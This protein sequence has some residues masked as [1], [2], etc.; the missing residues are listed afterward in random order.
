MFVQSWDS[1]VDK[2]IP[3]YLKL[4]IEDTASADSPISEDIPG[5]IEFRKCFES[6]L[7]WRLEVETAA[8]FGTSEDDTLQL[9]PRRQD[10]SA[11]AGEASIEFEQAND[12]AQAMTG[13]IREFQQTRY[14]LWRR[15]AEL[16]AGVPVSQRG[17]EKAHLALR[18]EAILK[19][20]AK[21]LGCQSAALYMLDDATT[22]L[23]LRASWGLPKKRLLAPA[24]PLRGAAG[25]LEALV[26]HA[27]VMKDTSQLPHWRV[28]EDCASAICVPVSSPTEPLGTLWYFCDEGR[29]F[30]EDQTNLAE[31][32]AGRVAAEL[33][34]EM[35]LNECV[36][37]EELERE[38][39]NAARWQ[40]ERLPS[41][42]PLLEDWD[43]AGWTSAEN[44]L[45]RAFHD[46]FVPPDGSLA[47]A[48]GMAEGSMLES[49]LTAGS[50]HAI[51]RAHSSYAHDAVEMLAQANETFWNSS[52]GGQF[53]SVF[54][55]L[56]QPETGHC[57]WSLAGGIDAF[58][59]SANGVEQFSGNTAVLGAEPE[60]T[61]EANT[62]T[63]RSGESLVLVSHGLLGDELRAEM[64][65]KTW[66][67]QARPQD[68]ERT[69]EGLMKSVRQFLASENAAELDGAL[70]VIRRRS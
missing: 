5:L 53:A 6:T 1:A 26:G 43:I 68:G 24:R 17:D 69:A 21:A 19:G 56:I 42:K 64:A 46:W 30:S 52:A 7:G 38:L 32:I 63:L 22:Q 14:E 11:R 28:P 13:L 66:L 67:E 40:Q 10:E 3:D 50:L 41:I 20:G 33:Q 47:V 70:L 65:F 48:L 27:V 8:G 45:G 23:K 18:L 29:E 25:D 12:L 62:V 31:I 39:E 55:G 34:R 61:G 4:H 57:E 54:Y 15:E 51:L 2:S 16:A 60:P 37:S 59:T 36:A 35:L 9:V 58:V 44:L 49:A